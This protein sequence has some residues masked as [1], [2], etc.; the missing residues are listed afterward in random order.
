MNKR[1]TEEEIKRARNVNLELYLPYRGYTLGAKEGK[2]YE[3]KVE[4]LK[5]VYVKG[6]MYI[7]A[8]KATSG[9][10]IQFLMEELDFKYFPDAVQELLAF[11]DLNKMKR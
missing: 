4:Q 6:M 1:F 11:D 3:R 9:D 8:W 7:N 5:G 2:H 10:A